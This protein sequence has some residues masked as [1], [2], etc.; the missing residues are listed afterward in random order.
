M[1]I[2]KLTVREPASI[3]ALLNRVERSVEIRTNEDHSFSF[4]F[5]FLKASLEIDCPVSIASEANPLTAKLF[6]NI[7]TCQIDSLLEHLDGNNLVSRTGG[8]FLSERLFDFAWHQSFEVCITNLNLFHVSANKK[9]QQARNH[10][11][12][13]GFCSWEANL[14]NKGFVS[15]ND[16]YDYKFCLI[17]MFSK[18]FIVLIRRMKN[19]TGMELELRLSI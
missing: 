6:A 14:A 3:E 2:I 4:M 18:E 16:K 11:L 13:Y 17:P 8:E 7:K 1:E 15:D 12:N 10:S 19:N 5:K 9:S